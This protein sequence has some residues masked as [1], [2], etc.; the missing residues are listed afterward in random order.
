M[1]MVEYYIFMHE[2][3]KMRK[4]ETIQEWGINENDGGG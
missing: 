3:G 4:S 1:N 2:N